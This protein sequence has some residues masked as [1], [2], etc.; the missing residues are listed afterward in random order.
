VNGPGWIPTARSPRRSPDAAGQL[1]RERA[2][3]SSRYAS[4]RVVSRRSP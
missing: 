1:P 4:A 2:S 3:A